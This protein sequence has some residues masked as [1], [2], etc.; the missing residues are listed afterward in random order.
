MHSG[1]SRDNFRIREGRIKVTSRRGWGGVA[2]SNTV[3]EETSSSSQEK[4]ALKLYFDG[5]P[6]RRRAS[7]SVTAPTK[8]RTDG[9]LK[10]VQ[11]ERLKNNDK[12]LGS[13]QL[14]GRRVAAPPDALLLF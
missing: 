1:D 12:L 9:S 14:W 3:V 13:E 8:G 10:I 6:N 11:M 5:R 2:G 7:C 4:R